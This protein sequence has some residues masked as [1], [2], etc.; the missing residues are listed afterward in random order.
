[1]G[2]GVPAIEKSLGLKLSGFVCGQKF[3]VGIALA[4]V[5]SRA[6]GEVRNLKTRKAQRAFISSWFQARPD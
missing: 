2:P 5:L 6:A 3:G 4:R 1:M